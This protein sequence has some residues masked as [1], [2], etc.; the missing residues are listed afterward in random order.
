M[1]IE[2]AP[3]GALSELVQRLEIFVVGLERAA[4]AEGFTQ[5]FHDDAMEL[6]PAEFARPRSSRQSSLVDEAGDEGAPPPLPGQRGIEVD[7]VDAR[8]DRARAQGRGAA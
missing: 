5:I 4:R 6:E 7:L 8:R 3:S 1:G 2:E